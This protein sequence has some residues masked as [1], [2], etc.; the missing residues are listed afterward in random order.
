MTYGYYNYLKKYSPEFLLKH[1][2]WKHEAW[3]RRSNFLQ[4]LN[5][6]GAHVLTSRVFFLPGIRFKTIWYV[7]GGLLCCVDVWGIWYFQ[8][9]YNKYTIHKWTNYQ[10]WFHQQL[11][12]KNSSIS[13]DPVEEKKPIGRVKYQDK[14]KIIYSGLDNP[15]VSS[16]RRY[17]YR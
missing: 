8:E 15:D 13:I 7:L 12:D 10:P 16:D 17:R 1:E 14:V 11:Q 2:S 9:I 3:S 6:K 4:L 5:T